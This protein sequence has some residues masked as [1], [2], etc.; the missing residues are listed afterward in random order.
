MTGSNAAWPLGRLR[1]PLRRNCRAFQKRGFWRERGLGPGV[2]GEGPRKRLGEPGG[3]GSRPAARRPAGDARASWPPP[4]RRSAVPDAEPLVLF[5]WTFKKA[6]SSIVRGR[7]LRREARGSRAAPGVQV[8]SGPGA[9][10]VQTRRRRRERRSGQT[11]GEDLRGPS[12]PARA[13]RRFGR[14]FSPCLLSPRSRA[15]VASGHQ[16]PSFQSSGCHSCAGWLSGDFICS[17][18]RGPSAFL[19]RRDAADAPSADTGERFREE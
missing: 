13:R 7:S 19:E 17:R 3:P 2:C 4:R 16:V 1:G 8:L 6:R 9:H 18:K 15:A 14:A 11:S 10:W 12:F 5:L